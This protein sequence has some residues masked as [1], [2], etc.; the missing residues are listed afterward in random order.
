[1]ITL[2]RWI[3][4]KQKEIKLKLAFYSMIE[5]IVKEQEDIIKTIAT[6]YES[7]K[8]ASGKEFQDKL[9]TAIAE[10]AHE[11]SVKEREKNK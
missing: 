11:Q 6:I 9:I 8:N 1:M 2:F 4:L 10:M 7:L 3:L 5:T